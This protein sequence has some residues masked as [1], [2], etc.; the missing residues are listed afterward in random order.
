M[1]GKRSFNES[2]YRAMKN[3]LNNR[4]KI[5]SEKVA[6]IKLKYGLSETTMCRVARSKNLDDYDRENRRNSALNRARR[7]L[8]EARRRERI[9]ALFAIMFFVTL[10]FGWIA[11]VV[12]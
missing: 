8:R 5:W 2:Q 9:I 4:T 7:K 3:L 1:S 11:G 6:I 10:L 12:L